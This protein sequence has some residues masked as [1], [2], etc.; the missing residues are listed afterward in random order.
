MR[1]HL[2]PDPDLRAFTVA[3][4]A[5]KTW[6]RFPRTLPEANLH[7]YWRDL[8]A[9]L[10]TTAVAD[11]KSLLT[12]SAAD[13]SYP[14]ISDRG[15]FGISST[16]MNQLLRAVEEV[17]RVAVEA[18]VLQRWTRQAIAT[19]QPPELSPLQIA[20]STGDLL[21]YLGRLRDICALGVR[22]GYGVLMTLWEE[23]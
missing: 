12:A 16:N 21:L 11:G 3:P 14:D 10:R 1:L 20:S 18:Y 2:A 4:T 9:I 13:W 15:A 22:K 19:G 5:L 8:D 6:L 17:D 23:P 7:E